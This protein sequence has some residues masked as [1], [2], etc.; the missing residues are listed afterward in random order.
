[1]ETRPVCGVDLGFGSARVGPSSVGRRLE[2]G[3]PDDLGETLKRLLA[4]L[5]PLGDACPL[6]HS[7]RR[8]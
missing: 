6:P 1:M 2:G 4:A 7:R 5:D 8:A 3:P